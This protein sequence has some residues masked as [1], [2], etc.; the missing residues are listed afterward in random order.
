MYEVAVHG[1]QFCSALWIGGRTSPVMVLSLKTSIGKE[2][3]MLVRLLCKNRKSS[4]AESFACCST[5]TVGV[6]VQVALLN[7]KDVALMKTVVVEV[8]SSVTTEVIFWYTTAVVVVAASS[9]ELIVMVSAMVVAIGRVAALLH[10]EL[11]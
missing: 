11:I 2:E 7:V 5:S 6:G 8:A 4:A 1:T 3:S 10:P 9:V